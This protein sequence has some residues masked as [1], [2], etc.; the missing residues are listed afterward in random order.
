MN[1]QRAEKNIRAYF[2]ETMDDYKSYEPINT[3][4][5]TLFSNFENDNYSLLQ[6][7]GSLKTE[8]DDLTGTLRI[9]ESTGSD[10]IAISSLQKKIVLLEDTILQIGF[11][12]DT[13]RKNYTTK[14]EGWIVLHEYRCKNK[15]GG[16]ELKSKYFEMD[17]DFNISLKSKFSKY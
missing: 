6:K 14:F 1:T 5:D 13:L 10:K 2:K 3:T 8:I 4:I 17:K 7:Q 9:Y 11:K 12:L 16:V 15:Y